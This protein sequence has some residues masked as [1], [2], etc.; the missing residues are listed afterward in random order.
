MIPTNVPQQ[1]L[2]MLVYDKV[3]DAFRKSLLPFCCS[4]GHTRYKIHFLMSVPCETVILRPG[5][6]GK[7]NDEYEHQLVSCV[8]NFVIT[9]GNVVFHR[10]AALLDAS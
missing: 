9:G 6:T 3:R 7:S 1:F 10:L 2:Q 5:G 8:P 4:L